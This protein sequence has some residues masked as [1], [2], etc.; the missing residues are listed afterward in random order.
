MWQ[1]F[2]RTT[3]GR[4][5]IGLVA[6]AVALLLRRLLGPLLGVYTP[7]ITLYPTVILLAMYAGV[8]PSVVSVICGVLGVTYWFMQHRSS[9]QISTPAPVVGSFIFLLVSACIIAAGEFSRRSQT[10]LRRAKTLFEAFLDNS[11]GIEYL[12]DPDGR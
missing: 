8:G 11:P 12:K 9:F 10:R 3:P 1:R 6:T 5:S 2:S 7:Y 4:Y